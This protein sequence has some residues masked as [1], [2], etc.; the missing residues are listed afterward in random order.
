M[1]IG[2]AI[3]TRQGRTAKAT[4]EVIVLH[5][6]DVMFELALTPS[7]L[8]TQEYPTYCHNGCRA[9]HPCANRLANLHITC[10]SEA[11]TASDTAQNDNRTLARPETL[12]IV[13]LS[14]HTK[15]KTVNSIHSDYACASRL[16]SSLA[17]C[18]PHKGS[19]TNERTN[20]QRRFRRRARRFRCALP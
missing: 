4:S 19:N 18:S 14:G 16:S 9:V 7:Q 8:M 13:T 10:H 6:D 2:S 3:T 1:P 20:C 5:A 11:R 17:G 15:M 12:R